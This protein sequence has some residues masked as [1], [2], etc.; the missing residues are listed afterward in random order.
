M[1]TQS[2]GLIVGE[3]APWFRARAVEGNP[4]YNYATI[5]GRYSLLCFYGSASTPEAQQALQEVAR[6]RDVFDDTHCCFFGVSTDPM[7]ETH[8][9]VQ[10]SLPG[11][12]HFIDGDGRVSALYRFA[13]V[14][15]DKQ[16]CWIMV[17]PMLRIIG[18]FPLDRGAQ[19]IESI[20]RISR[21]QSFV[22]HAP[23]LIVPYIFEPALC[24][25]LIQLFDAAGGEASGFMREVDG[26]TVALH[27]P[28]H[29]IRKDHLI[30]DLKLM[31][32][33]Q[34]LVSRRLVP[35]VKRAFNFETTR[36][37][38]YLVCCYD[39][40]DGGHFAAHRDNTTKGTAHRKFAVSIN[41]NTEDYEGGDLLFPEY[42]TRTYRPPTGGA[43]VFSCSMLHQATPVTRGRR[44][45]FVPFLY[46][47][48]AAALRERNNEYL[49]DPAS[50]YSAGTRVG[51][52]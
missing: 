51:E 37:E 4:N 7:D 32:M 42:G 36:M 20:A 44:F 18:R 29:K 47:E 3:P 19:A 13:Q 17:D 12:R 15:D 34:V 16:L 24:Q 43:C 2:T 41:L 26:K 49:A 28:S 9:R 52:A 45:V 5:G 46:D 10:Q 8:R 1:S 39:S 31:H 38:R 50:H 14:P 25:Q 30:E 48:E 11:I 40:K 22:E 6:S 35:M 33:L 23:V 21:Q 27:D